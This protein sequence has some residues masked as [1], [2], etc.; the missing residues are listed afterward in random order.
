VLL[1]ELDLHSN[2]L[3][4]TL[5]PLAGLFDLEDLNLCSNSLHG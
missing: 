5:E 4:G 1:R 3:T 2:Q